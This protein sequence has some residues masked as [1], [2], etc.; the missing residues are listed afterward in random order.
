MNVCM[1][2]Y[3]PKVLVQLYFLQWLFQ[4]CLRDKNYFHSYKSLQESVASPLLFSQSNFRFSSIG[5][6]APF[7]LNVIYS[8]K[9][10]L[11]FTIANT[12]QE[13][14]TR[15][16]LHEICISNVGGCFIYIA[17]L[18]ISVKCF[19]SHQFPSSY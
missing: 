3:M 2:I 15:M 18:D 11:L 1:Y 9:N 7:S 16:S 13:P 19:S 14:C 5:K 10:I 12:I 8:L 17:F 6:L 4:S